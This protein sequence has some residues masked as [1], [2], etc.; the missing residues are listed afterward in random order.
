MGMLQEQSKSLKKNHVRVG[1]WSRKPGEN[2]SPVIG[3]IKN[4]GV[5]N[6]T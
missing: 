6:E 4:P 1:V 3:S 2:T 5:I